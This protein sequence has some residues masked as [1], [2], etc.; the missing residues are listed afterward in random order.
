MIAARPNQIPQYEKANRPVEVEAIKIKLPHSRYQHPLTGKMH[1]SLPTNPMTM[2]CQ[3][4]QSDQSLPSMITPFELRHSLSKLG[5][6]VGYFGS[7]TQS[8]KPLFAQK[9]LGKDNILGRKPLVNSNF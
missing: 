5:G 8:G 9:G 7:S 4:N 3:R 6:I 1:D 2:L